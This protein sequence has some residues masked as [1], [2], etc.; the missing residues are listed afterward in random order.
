MKQLQE[1][2]LD[3]EDVL[4]NDTKNAAKNSKAL[5][6]LDKLANNDSVRDDGDDAY[7]RKLNRGDIVI[8]GS[9]VGASF[10][11]VH[12]VNEEENEC[13]LVWNKND[14]DQ[15]NPRHFETQECDY[16]IKIDLKILEQIIK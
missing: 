14:F 13:T 2:L 9:E 4:M 16:L 6:I 5:K 1:S 3:D 12:S 8:A 11:M 10:Y 7:G 15:E